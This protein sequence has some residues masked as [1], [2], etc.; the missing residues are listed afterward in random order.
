MF[1][2]RLGKAVHG[3]CLRN[4]PVEADAYLGTVLMGF[5]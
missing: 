5:I 1:N 4:G 3:F 2:L